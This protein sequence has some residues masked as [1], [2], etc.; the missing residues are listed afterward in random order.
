MYE[1]VR[2]FIER[3]RVLE[4]GQ[5][6]LVGVSG[7]PDSLVLMDVLHHLG[8]P[9]V[10]AHLNHSLRPEAEAEACQVQRMAED[11]GLTFILKKEDVPGYAVE[12]S[13][14][15]E[16][17]ARIVRYEF[18]FRQAVDHKC[19]AV[20]VGHNA[21]DQ[22]ETVVMHILRGSGLAGLR[23]MQ[24][25][26]MPN[27]WSQEI[28]LVRPLLPFWRE[29]ILAHCERHNLQPVFDRSNLDTTYFRNRLRNE[30]IPI[31]QQYNPAIRK[32]IWRMSNV[33]AGDHQLLEQVV[34]QA[35]ETCVLSYGPSH[36]IFDQSALMEKPVGL[37]RGLLRQGIS[38]LRS[39]LRDI[40]FN[41]V[42]R[43]LRFLASPSKTGQIDLIAGLRLSLENNRLILADWD[44][45][46]PADEWPQVTMDGSITLKTPG[47]MQLKDGWVLHSEHVKDLVTDFRQ[48]TINEDAFQAWVSTDNLSAPLLVRTRKT[49]DRIQPLG[50]E[51]HSVKLSEY[52]INLKIPRRV[53]DA[54]PLISTEGDIVWAPGIALAHPF[55]LTEAT[56][57]AV[58]M[59]LYKLES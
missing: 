11:R 49:G 32:I 41:C 2:E 22:V 59:K 43:G 17:A 52:M 21:D 31:L 27:S 24:L 58:Y 39:G 42:E 4:P 7:G 51:E 54:W 57:Q 36:V 34:E 25:R 6:V 20:A 53:R 28:A 26:A 15:V 44:A 3:E 10:V 40:D 1:R 48:A 50:M 19:Q 16:E 13:L 18:L 45:Q 12:H 35:W 9:L 55:R 5:V 47:Q 8:Y 30:L 14:A 46:I 33:L 23:G 56:R 38:T 37:K 29:E